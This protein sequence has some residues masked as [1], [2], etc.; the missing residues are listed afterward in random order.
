MLIQQRLPIIQYND[1]KSFLNSQWLMNNYLTEIQFIDCLKEVSNQ[2]G[3]LS[4][5][6]AQF[7]QEQLAQINTINQKVILLTYFLF[8]Y[9]IIYV[10]KQYFVYAL[11]KQ[12]L[13]IIIKISNKNCDQL[14]SIT[15]SS[16]PICKSIFFECVIMLLNQSTYLLNQADQIQV[17]NDIDDDVQNLLNSKLF[18]KMAY[19]TLMDLIK[20]TVLQNHFDGQSL[21]AICINQMLLTDQLQSKLSLDKI[22]N[23]RQHDT[24]YLINLMRLFIDNKDDQLH[25]TKQILRYIFTLNEERNCQISKLVFSNLKQLSHSTSLILQSIRIWLE[26]KNQIVIQQIRLYLEEYL[27]T[28]FN[29]IHDDSDYIPMLFQILS[30]IQSQGFIEESNFSESVF[31]ELIQIFHFLWHQLE[32]ET[33]DRMFAEKIEFWQNYTKKLRKQSNFTN[34]NQKSFP[35]TVRDCAALYLILHDQQNTKKYIN[36]A[37]S[38]IPY[39]DALYP[40]EQQQ[41]KDMQLMQNL[42]K[43]SV[44]F[45]VDPILKDDL[46]VLQT[47]EKVLTQVQLLNSSMKQKVFQLIWSRWSPENPFYV[48][49]LQ[50]IVSIFLENEDQQLGTRNNFF[51]SILAMESEKKIV[52]P[53]KFHTLLQICQYLCLENAPVNM[54]HIFSQSQDHNS[55][56]KLKKYKIKKSFQ[57]F[58]QVNNYYSM[59]VKLISGIQNTTNLVYILKEF[60]KL[61]WLL[62]EGL[63]L[64]QVEFADEFVQF[65]E[66]KLQVFSEDQMKELI[67]LLQDC[68]VSMVS[69][70]LKLKNTIDNLEQ[71]G[72]III[73]NEFCLKV[74]VEVFI[75]NSHPSEN[76]KQKCLQFLGVLLSFNEYNQLVFRECIRLSNFLQCMRYQRNKK[77]QQSM[78]DVLKRSLSFIRNDQIQ[79]MIQNAP[80]D[81]QKKQ[82]F[83]QSNFSQYVG[84]T[85]ETFSAISKEVKGKK[86]FQLLGKDSGIVI[87]NYQDLC[88]KKWR[89]FTILIEFKKESFYF[90]NSNAKHKDEVFKEEQVIFNMSGMF[91]TQMGNN[92][93][94]QKYS[95]QQVDLIKVALL[96]PPFAQENQKINPLENLIKISI[97]N[98]EQKPNDMYINFTQ[99][100]KDELILLAIIFE[101]KPK[102]TFFVK[103][104]DEPKKTYHIKS[105]LTEYVKKHSDKYHIT[106]NI[107]TYYINQQFQNTFQ[108]VINNFII[109]EKVLYLKQIEAV[110]QRNQNNL[111]E[112]IEKEVLQAGNEE[113]ESREMQYLDIEK[114]KTCFSLVEINDAIK[115]TK[116]QTIQ[117]QNF[118]MN[119]IKKQVSHKMVHESNQVVKVFYQ[120]VNIIEDAGLA[121]VFLSLDNIEI[122]LFIIQISTQ[123]YFNLENFERRSSRLKTLQVTLPNEAGRNQG[124]FRRIN[125]FDNLFR[126]YFLVKDMRKCRDDYLN[127]QQFH[128]NLVKSNSSQFSQGESPIEKKQNCLL[129]TSGSIVNSIIGG[130]NN[131]SVSQFV[132]DH[133][134][135]NQQHQIQPLQQ[136]STYGIDELTQNKQND[137]EIKNGA[138]MDIISVEKTTFKSQTEK[139]SSNKYIEDTRVKS[140]YVGRRTSRNYTCNTS[141]KKHTSLNQFNQNII[142]IQS[143]KNIEFTLEEKSPTHND[144]NIFQCEWIRVKLQVYGEL[145]VLEKG[146]V[147]QFQSDAKERPEQDFYTYGTISFNLRKVKLTKRLNTASII[148]IQTRRYS[149][150]E[151]AVEIFCK[152]KKSY[153]F[154]LYDTEKRNQF[155]NCFKQHYNISLVIDRRAEFQARNYTK[156][157][158]KG[159]IT[160]FE[161]LMLI[162]KYS[163]RSF[164]DLNQYP[165]FP[166]VI[167]DYTSKKIDLNNREQY[168]DLDKLISSQNKERLENIKTRAESLKQT[169]MEYFLFGSHYSVAAQIINTLVR[170][171]PFTSLQCDLQDGKL[172]Q[173]DRIFFSIPNTWVS[174]Q[175]DHQ[176]FRELIPEY[177]YFPEFLKNIN[178]IQFGIRQNS[179]VVDDVV[180]PPWAESCEEFIEINRKALESYFVSE[181]LHN[182]INLIFGPYS[183]GEEA[184][185]KDNLYHWLTYESCWQ[186][187]D[188]LPYQD[189]M[190]YLT[191]I[192]SFGQVP[193]QLFTKPHPQKQRLEQNLYFPS[194]LVKILT[195]KKL[196]NSKRIMKFDKKLIV[197]TYKENDNLYVLMNNC[198]VYKLKYNASLEKKESEEKLLSAQLFSIQE[199][200]KL[201]M[202]KCDILKDQQQVHETYKNAKPIHITGQQF[203]FDDHFLFV[204]GYLSGSVYIYDI[205]Q[206]KAQSPNVCHK[207]KLHRRR[208]TCLCYS[209]KLKVLC[210]GAKDN[211]V[212]VWKVQQSNEKTISFGASPKYILYGHDKSIKCL[213]IDEDMEIVISLDKVGKLQIHSVISGLFLNEIKIQLSVGEKIWNVISNGNGLIALLTTNSEIIVTRV[214]GFVVRRYVNNNIGQIT[215]IM[216]YQESHLLISTLKGE[217]LLIQDVSSL[218]E[219]YPLIFHIYQNTQKIGIINFSY[220]NIDI[221]IEFEN[222]GV[223]FLISLIDGSLYRLILS[224]GQNNDFQKYLGKLGM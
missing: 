5:E 49:I 177:F 136:H 50:Q 202:E 3:M 203:Q 121:D 53:Q 17:D 10:E 35:S 37:D 70:F 44:E 83:R 135:Q 8:G 6:K 204:A 120:G 113:I 149:H 128:L 190:G 91:E 94:G 152:N 144:T 222:E 214:N 123:T 147:L 65:L 100:T 134:E 201:H 156:K 184:R 14:L 96:K 170:I 19:I 105:F 56:L 71:Y 175:N 183:Q 28:S 39:I 192:Q 171:E 106:L 31:E 77:L 69:R 130:W 72:E 11:Y 163:G 148:E 131:P 151:I 198:S 161:Y 117:E 40:L 7:N 143:D 145:R 167:S 196:I 25:I 219:Q 46:V 211:R 99:K 52:H 217:I 41:V 64:S 42:I 104:Q 12:F 80:K 90:I 165:I 141:P 85:L 62:T 57:E 138:F 153:F 212:T 173:A 205:H 158:L 116:Y 224:A 112:I 21:I 166:W 33:N 199:V 86:Q 97:L 81:H 124:V 174:C 187:L 30:S 34:H 24:E 88:T 181:K 26:S 75:F 191:Q 126:Q 206:D 208:V 189:K 18:Y 89:S 1:Y 78:E 82:V 157:W 13:L 223:T 76:L 63:K 98:N 150:K 115:V 9:H 29:Q 2:V 92:F 216:F 32:Q 220:C 178:K 182:W 186:S 221:Q 84:A 125:Y 108:G 109:I 103:I 47:L 172:D 74:L 185:K 66:Q 155:L 118:L 95:L 22:K 36:P 137:P 68:S 55:C 48:K 209:P 213:T 133:S 58:F 15:S 107:G 16:H 132:L 194:N 111:I 193:F 127:C 160:N 188:K 79:K 43:S 164:N 210:L 169:Q 87:K 200:E 27:K 218:T 51:L 179:E 176:D 140:Q 114:F 38:L 195:D 20:D 162:N 54:E 197:K 23:I 122:I 159:K 61:E 154:V 139:L 101:D 129:D 45:L 180:L 60:I 146:K 110:F 102:H 67:E 142:E 73:Q 119:M 93:S 168:R 215:Q 4:K 207:I 59:I